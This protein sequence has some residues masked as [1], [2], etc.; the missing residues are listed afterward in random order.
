MKKKFTLALS[1]LLMAGMAYDYNHNAAHTF[2]N[3]APAGNTGSP[4]D[5]NNCATSCHTGGPAQSN[6]MVTISSDI[7]GSG[8]VAGTTYTFTVTSQQWRY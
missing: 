5:V 2:S 6:Q 3:G 7:P 1:M 8:Y 4:G